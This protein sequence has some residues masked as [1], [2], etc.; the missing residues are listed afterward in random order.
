MSIVFDTGA[1]AHMW[2]SRSGM[3]FYIAY[4][5]PRWIEGISKYA[6]GSGTTILTLVPFTQC[7]DGALCT[8]SP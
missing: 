3:D 5:H 4:P 7:P 8:R 2:G 1:T 6:H